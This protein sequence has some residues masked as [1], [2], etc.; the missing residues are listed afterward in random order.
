M[1]FIIK[2]RRSNLFWTAKLDA[3]WTDELDS[4][5][6]YETIEDAET[7]LEENASKY[8]YILH[9][10]DEADVVIDEPVVEESVVEESDIGE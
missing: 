6:R 9:V 4:A 1:A 3:V 2:S 8:P 5:Q 7:D 10:V